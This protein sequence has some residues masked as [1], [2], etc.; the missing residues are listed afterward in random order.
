[1]SL[2]DTARNTVGT[3]PD[4]LNND[5][6]SGTWQAPRGEWTTTAISKDGVMCAVSTEKA[7]YH[8]ISGTLQNG[9]CWTGKKR[10][11]G[12]GRQWFDVE[13]FK[14]LVFVDT[15]PKEAFP[16]SLT[17]SNSCKV[18]FAGGFRKRS[19][20]ESKTPNFPPPVLRRCGT[21]I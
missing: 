1:M 10:Q 15:F 11:G 5:F 2:V 20:I 19:I 17:L 8:R 12:T 3:A 14:G 7:P 13:E 9:L 4:F 6:Q 21:D 16:F 18:Y